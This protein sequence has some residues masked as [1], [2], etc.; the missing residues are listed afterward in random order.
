MHLAKAI[1][2]AGRL[3]QSVQVLTASHGGTKGPE[4]YEMKSIAMSPIEDQNRVVG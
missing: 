4:K 1:P 3:N 2:T